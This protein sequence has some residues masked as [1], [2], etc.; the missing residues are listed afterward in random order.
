MLCQVSGQTTNGYSELGLGGFLQLLSL[1][2]DELQ[3]KLQVTQDQ[4]L[5]LCKQLVIQLQI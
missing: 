1:A 3:A 2:K 5:Q 4:T